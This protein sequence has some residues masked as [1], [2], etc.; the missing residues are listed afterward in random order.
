M[1][2]NDLFDKLKNLQEQMKR[3]SKLIANNASREAARQEAQNDAQQT[4]FKS[5]SYKTFLERV[6][7]NEDQTANVPMNDYAETKPKS[8]YYRESLMLQQAPN[9][10]GFSKAVG[11]YV[12]AASGLVNRID[13]NWYNRFARTPPLDPFTANTTTREYIFITKPDLHLFNGQGNPNPELTKR[14]AFF[15]DALERF[16]GVARQL[17]YSYFGPTGGPF[18]ALLSNAFTGHI[19]MPGITAETVD[20][21]NN[22][23]GVHMS[24]R[25]SSYDS[26]IQPEVSIEFKDNKYLEVYMLL[27]MYDEY[28][29]LKWMGY[30]TPTNEIY[31]YR[32]IL[33]DQVTLYKIVVAED[34]MSIMYWAR[35]T[36]GMVTSIPRDYFGDELEGDI[37]YNTSWKFNF[38]SDMD[39]TILTDFNRIT[40]PQRKGKKLLPLYDTN[41]NI[42]NPVWPVSPAIY[43]STGTSRGNRYRKYMLRWVN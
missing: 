27:K 42:A 43:M 9:E 39:P 5:Q 15:K 33:H 19:D 24:Y 3:G 40:A 16:P 26:D 14:S 31:T 18:M 2:S 32:K 1:A 38:M 10:M 4:Y 35:F 20:T 41:N 29:R 30:V 28:E 13:M 25:G 21:S 36:G 7:A 22:V 11:D 12:S 6:K 17:Q 37:T 23:Y 34:G 8:T